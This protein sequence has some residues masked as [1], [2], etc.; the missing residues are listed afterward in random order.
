MRRLPLL[1]LVLA[2]CGQDARENGAAPLPS[3]LA[4]LTLARRSTEIPPVEFPHARH[5]DAS[6]VRES[7]A[8]SRCHHPLAEDA[9]ALP[10][11]CGSC[12]PHDAVAGGPPDI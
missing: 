7:L 6:V 4:H 3:P 2:A 11:R 9:E 12:H 1:C 10:A 8:C 5:L